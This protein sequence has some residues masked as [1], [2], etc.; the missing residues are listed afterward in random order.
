[1]DD[2]PWSTVACQALAADIVNDFFRPHHGGVLF[3]VSGGGKFLMQISVEADFMAPAADFP[4][5]LGIAFG[6][7]AWDKKGSLKV[8]GI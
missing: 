1:M 3:L 6:D 4:D 2:S 5:Y 7:H 8:P